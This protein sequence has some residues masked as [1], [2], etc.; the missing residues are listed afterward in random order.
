MSAEQAIEHI[1]RACLSKHAYS[2]KEAWI[3]VE[4]MRNNK[5]FQ[6]PNAHAYQCQYCGKWH[7]AS[8][9]L[10]KPRSSPR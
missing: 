1:N 6:K 7:A 3:V 2:E 5:R 4:R 10:K 8:R 9:A